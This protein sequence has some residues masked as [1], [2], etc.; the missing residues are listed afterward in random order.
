[1]NILIIDDEEMV[2]RT[3]SDYF[4]DEDHTVVTADSGEQGLEAVRERKMDAAIVDMRLPGMDGND[5]ILRAREIHPDL[6]VLIHTGSVDYTLPET[7]KDIGLTNA[8]IFRK[9]L[10]SI[11]I[12]LEALASY[13]SLEQST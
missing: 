9:P 1:M 6:K 5:F 8:H 12:L 11:G 3:L 4:E 13:D 2:R 10:K 7:L